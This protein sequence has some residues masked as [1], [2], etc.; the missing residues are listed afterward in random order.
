[1][2]KRSVII[3]I[4]AGLRGKYSQ[5][6]HQN[7]GLIIHAIHPHPNVV[8]SLNEVSKF[9][10]KTGGRLHVHAFA[11]SDSDGEVAY[12]LTNDI[13]SSSILPLSTQNL[14]R[15]KAPIGRRRVTVNGSIVVKTKTLSSFC[16]EI[17]LFGGITYINIDVTGYAN[18]VL[19]GI[20]SQRL[21]TSIKEISVKVHTVDFDLYEGQTK[22]SDIVDVLMLHGFTQTAMKLI[23]FDQESVLTY[24][25]QAAVQLG[26]PFDEY[27]FAFRISRLF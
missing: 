21:W 1:M 24:R 23:S 13:H 10:L 14:R 8:S 3:D 12:Q 9:D 26:W 7:P 17:G 11:A 4:G 25:N 2:D 18:K 15:W 22:L 5:L 19:D 6:L 16:D 20:M 27:G